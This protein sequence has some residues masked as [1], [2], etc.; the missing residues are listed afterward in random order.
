MHLFKPTPSNRTMTEI[1]SA[2]LN[3]PLAESMI[4][5]HGKV[6][7]VTIKSLHPENRH[8][9]GAHIWLVPRLTSD[10]EHSSKN[11]SSPEGPTNCSTEGIE[12]CDS[13]TGSQQVRTKYSNLS[14]H[15]PEML[16]RP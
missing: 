11:T 5:D 3:E 13:Y 8:N 14:W 15:W 12:P 6:F 4:H 10:S 2:A 7:S 1:I 16:Q 9:R